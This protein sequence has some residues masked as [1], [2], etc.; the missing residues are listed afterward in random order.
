MDEYNA[1]VAN[2]W[3][4]HKDFL[5]PHKKSISNAMPKYSKTKDPAS[6]NSINI[7]RKITTERPMAIHPT[8]LDQV[9]EKEHALLNFKDQLSKFKPKQSVLEVNI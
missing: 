3:D 1:Q 7:M 5:Q 2:V 9:D 8:L 4:I 6:Q